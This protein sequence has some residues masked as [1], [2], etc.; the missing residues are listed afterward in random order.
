MQ[1]HCRLRNFLVPLLDV[2]FFP[3]FFC[4]CSPARLVLGLE[5]IAEMTEPDISDAIYS[6]SIEA[7]ARAESSG[8]HVEGGGEADRTDPQRPAVVR[9]VS[10]EEVRYPAG[11]RRA[12]FIINPRGG[13]GKALREWQRLIPEVERVFGDVGYS[14]RVTT[15]PWDA[16]ALA[17]EL[18][19]EGGYD[20]I[21]SVGGDGT[22]NEVANGLVR[23]GGPARGVD[24]AT[25]SIGSGSDLDK[26]L[27]KGT[28]LSN[29]E[30]LELF[31]R[32]GAFP[33]DL[34]LLRC[35]TADFQGTEL[36][37]R[38]RFLGPAEASG[39]QLQV[40]GYRGGAVAVA[41]GVEERL[42]LNISGVGI[43][44]AVCQVVNSSSK[45]LGGFATFCYATV[46]ISLT[47]KNPPVRWHHGPEEEWVYARVYM[48]L[49]GNGQFQGGGM[50]PVP[51]ADMADGLLDL[52][53]I[54]DFG[55]Q[56]VLKIPSIYAGTHFQHT[57]KVFGT[58][59]TGVYIEPT[60][61]HNPA[62]IEADGE[63]PGKLP[64]CFHVIPS[65]IHIIVPDQ[66]LLSR[67]L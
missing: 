46:R 64:A 18:V 31:A 39:A 4:L 43:G 19:A 21:V 5:N 56:D 30:K 37:P 17:A 24:F 63:T 38:L 27:Y 42:F 12:G 40:A 54:Q 6:A 57:P 52:V 23:G 1:E 60:D 22:H 3:G 67:L 26:T 20:V 11:K 35:A 65:S 7:S 29:L 25:L 62:W 47:W 8:G 61:P 49:C 41:E 59:T 10:R 34:G 58:R 13:A 50:R 16:A 2:V 48:F 66:F 15:G 14:V 55:L 51:H 53:V 32:G 9:R 45:A 28:Q 33:C 36:P 44:G